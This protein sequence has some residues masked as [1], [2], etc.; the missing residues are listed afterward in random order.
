MIRAL[1]WKEW[2]AHGPMLALLLALA[3]IILYLP[4]VFFTGFRRDWLEL[5]PLVTALIAWAHGLLLGALLTGNDREEGTVLYLDCLPA[6]RARRF[7][8]LVFLALLF[9]LP[10]LALMLPGEKLG[11]AWAEIPLHFSILALGAASLMGLG[12]GMAMGIRMPTVLSAFGMGAAVQVGV[13]LAL[14]VISAGLELVIHFESLP[15]QIF[16]VFLV[17]PILILVPWPLAWYW[18]TA[19]DQSCSSNLQSPEAMESWLKRAAW[20]CWP[21]LWR[22]LAWQ[23]PVAIFLGL[24]LGASPFLWPGWTLFLGAFWGMAVIAPEQQSGGKRWWGMMRAPLM[25]YWGI[26]TVLCLFTGLTAL[27]LTLA[28]QLGKTLVPGSLILN[29]EGFYQAEFGGWPG[30]GLFIPLLP[31]VF[32]WFLPGFASALFWGPWLKKPVIGLILGFTTGGLLSLPWIPSLL[33]G[34]L[35]FLPTLIPPLVIFAGAIAWARPWVCET[36]FTGANVRLAVLFLLLTALSF[37]TLIA[38]RAQEFPQRQD[39]LGLEQLQRRIQ[40]QTITPQ[41]QKLRDR[42][43]RAR[44]IPVDKW[45]DHAAIHGWKSMGLALGESRANLAPGEKVKPPVYAEIVANMRWH[46]EQLELDKAPLQPVE[47]PVCL[48]SWENPNFQQDQ[49]LIQAAMAL[50]RVEAAWALHQAGLGEEKFLAEKLALQ[51][52]MARC[53][54]HLAPLHFARAGYNLEEGALRMAAACLEEIPIK[55]QTVEDLA[56]GLGQHKKILASMPPA[57][58]RATGRLYS[59]KALDQPLNYFHFLFGS[60]NAGLNPSQ[61]LWW[62]AVG[63]AWQ[64][65]WEKSRLRAQTME[66]FSHNRGEEANLRLIPGTFLSTIPFWWLNPSRDEEEKLKKSERAL[67]LLVE[68][69][70][71]MRRFHDQ[72]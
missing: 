25:H 55:T 26:Q 64:A 28:T 48:A 43:Y 39:S 63:E 36:L 37:L 12:W 35:T 3:S 32:L 13:F 5:Q 58:L 52:S 57:S 44:D 53:F 41:F 20:L 45:L 17:W 10:I 59:L 34:G 71:A 6:S 50:A 18:Y 51:L 8:I 42:L 56:Q 61:T 72:H 69:G 31:W 23:A 60:S 54:F 24:Y 1:F 66:W 33:A 65:P 22:N 27:S 62:S 29:R 21:R 46:R 4:M 49:E 9:Q 38:L 67:G 47:D 11:V 14:A 15:F 19:G 68:G 30:L 2:R 7:R 16:V 40:A 70:L